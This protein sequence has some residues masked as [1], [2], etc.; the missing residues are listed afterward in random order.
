MRK[1]DKKIDNK[2]RQVL[3]DV[4]D[5]ALENI[6]GY[7]WI[8][9]TVNYSSFPESLIITCVF[10]NQENALQAKQ[11]GE[12]FTLILK[13]LTNISVNLTAPQ[14]QIRFEVE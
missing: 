14:K 4:C 8:S 11:Q 9:H 2:L 5:F 10:D 13:A 6:T 1:T 7:Q 3:T 12:L